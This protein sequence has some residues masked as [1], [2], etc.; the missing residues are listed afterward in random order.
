MKKKISNLRN[1]FANNKSKIASKAA[2]GSLFV[3]CL[4]YMIACDKPV[5]PCNDYTNPDCQN[6]DPERVRMDSLRADSVEYA[7]QIKQFT[8][9]DLD[10]VAQ[11]NANL[12]AVF[13]SL[14]VRG[15][16]YPENFADSVAGNN[17]GTHNGGY[18]FA[19]DGMLNNS[20]VTE[21]PDAL[22]LF[23]KIKNASTAY[24]NNNTALSH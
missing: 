24:L 11:Q 5:P 18:V 17:N 13:W 16:P 15:P 23:D 14:A 22:V 12:K 21:Y 1:L 20:A 9:P 10:L 8:G 6:Y 3:V 7:N 4:A 2:V 19:A